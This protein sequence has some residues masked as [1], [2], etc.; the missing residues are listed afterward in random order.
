MLLNTGNKRERV[1]YHASLAGP[2]R[3]LINSNCTALSHSEA[4]RNRID[5]STYHGLSLLRDGIELQ[6]LLL[7]AVGHKKRTCRRNLRHVLLVALLVVFLGNAAKIKNAGVLDNKLLLAAVL[8]HVRD[9]VLEDVHTDLLEHRVHCS[10][11]TAR[12]V[13]GKLQRFGRRRFHLGLSFGHVELV[14]RHV[15]DACCGRHLLEVGV[16]LV[17]VLPAVR[18]HKI[19]EIN[20]ELV[21]V[22]ENQK[23]NTKITDD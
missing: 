19:N 16:E 15:E 23:V 5:V 4:D 1:K 10:R 13:E 7:R 2:A 8:H 21:R 3:K 20:L 6:S 18:L 22:P 14:L 17:L 12:Y 9:Q 11:A